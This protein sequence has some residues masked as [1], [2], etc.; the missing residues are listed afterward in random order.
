MSRRAAVAA[1]VAAALT[2]PMLPATTAHAETPVPPPP[3][4]VGLERQPG[5]R[6]D[7]NTIIITFER[8]QS[9]P[10]QAATDVVEQPADRVAGATIAKVSPI[11][12][13]M[14]AV[15]LDR[16]VTPAEAASI[17]SR[18]ERADQVKA[19]EPA[20]TFTTDTTNDVYYSYLWNLQAESTTDYGVNAESVWP[21]S[22]GAGVVVGVVDTGITAH[23]DLTGSSTATVGGNVIAGYDFI[24]DAAAAGDGNG[25][26]NNPADNGDYC[27][28]DPLDKTSSW[29]GTHVAG[30]I[31]ALRNNSRGVVGVAPGAKIEPL[32]ALGRCGGAEADII[33]AILWGA[34]VTVLGLPAN[35][36]PAD[37]LNLSLGGSGTCTTAMQSAIDQAVARGVPVVVAA[38]NEDQAL[39]LSAPANCANVIRV[40]ATT[41]EGDRA[42]YSNYGTSDDPATLAA[43]GGSGA[44]SN[45]NDWIVSTWNSG[46]TGPGTAAYAGMVGTS[47]AAPHVAAVAALLLA[48]DPSLGPDQ[49]ESLLASTATRLASCSTTACG[50]GVVNAPRAM[51]T[52]LNSPAKD[53]VANLWGSF[54]LGRTVTVTPYGMPDVTFTFQ[55]MRAGSPIQGATSS[56]YTLVPADLGSEV[57]A[58]VTAHYLWQTAVKTTPRTVVYESLDASVPTPVISGDPMPGAK[59]S[60]N[61]TPTTLGADTIRWLRDGVQV[62]FDP[63]FTLRP[64]DVGHEFTLTHIVTFEGDRVERTSDPVTIVANS[65]TSLA[66]PEI[67]GTAGVGATLTTVGAGAGAASYTFQWLRNGNPISGGTAAAYPVVAADE[68]SSLTVTV[69]ATL[70]GQTSSLTSSPV[71]VPYRIDGLA[72]PVIGGQ[73]MV[74][75]KLSTAG[76][77]A[78]GATYT[79]RWLRNGTSITGATA[80]GYTLTSSDTG[81][82]VSVR[83]TATLS[84]RTASRTSDP[85]TVLANSVTTL[86]VPVITGTPQ[87][88][89]TLST[90]GTGAEGATYTY[91]WYRSGT[92]ISGATGATRTL[93][94]YDYGKVMTVKVTAS[95]LGQKK[96]MTSAGTTKVAP[97]PFTN[98][99]L[100]S[101]T[102]TFKKGYTVKAKYGTWSP[103]PS[104]VRYRWLRNGASISGATYSSYRLT[105][106]DR[107][108]NI[109]VRIT[110][111]RT[112]YVT[113][114]AYSPAQ[115]VS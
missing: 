7:T 25:R 85:V 86:Q 19:A 105:S 22:T 45:M 21:I 55:W 115:L 57:W 102:G 95:Y 2:L 54:L 92:A 65:V 16:A 64:A 27:L 46:T 20:G 82:Q 109:S 50:A 88:G 6:P 38:G 62:G 78:P 32:R 63:T 9:D 100:P 4:V 34:G 103:T 53:F 52:L 87:G 72:T 73:P 93:S 5:A 12:D 71:A 51:N 84:G 83:V 37:V 41:W 42:P 67:S 30:I 8:A 13:T 113:A 23:P 31:A 26:D 104:T 11:T 99:V 43:P 49:V 14:V 44:S 101:L 74:G 10:K 47:M 81:A 18:A 3:P 90:A 76:S 59:L 68:G 17:G 56:A 70:Y 15:T 94:R 69:T 80:A 58:E 24:S 96:S 66:V 107:G 33:A 89:L 40:A 110:V 77:G 36:S 108:K 35:P 98:T 61:Y 112:G 28:S 48:K 106:S 29:H 1:T 39:S 91:Q 114:T 60:F 97:A 75:G 79:Y 111:Y